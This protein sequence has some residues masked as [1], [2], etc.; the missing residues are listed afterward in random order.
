M[1]D[2]QRGRD[3]ERLLENPLLKEAF[4]EIEKYQIS[5]WRS[6]VGSVEDSAWTVRE[7][8]QSILMGLD[9][10]REQLASFV[11]TGKMAETKKNRPKE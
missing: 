1:N 8:A 4:E 10:F 7:S 5:R 9:A 6:V 2:V 11:T 3:A